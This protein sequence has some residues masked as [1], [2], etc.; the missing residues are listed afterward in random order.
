MAMK[1]RM[2]MRNFGRILCLLGLLVLGACSQEHTSAYSEQ[3][4]EDNSNTM[5]VSVSLEATVDEEQFKAISFELKNDGPALLMSEEDVNSVVVI[6]NRSKSSVYYS[7]IKWKKKTGANALSYAGTLTDL[8]T[9]RP[10]RLSSG[11]EWFMMGYLG[12]TY[13][14]ASKRVRFNPNSGGGLRALSVGEKV[15]K[16]VPIYFPWAQLNLNS[17]GDALNKSIRF[18][19]LG[20]MM[21]VE[22]KNSNTYDVRFRHLYFSSHVLSTG[23][24]YYDLSGT[25]LPNIPTNLTTAVGAS[26]PWVADATAEP[27]YP[28]L[29]NDGT[30]LDVTVKAGGTYSKYFLVWA[31]PHSSTDARTKKRTITHLLADAVRVVNGQ[32]QATPKMESVYIWGST[33]MPV[34]RKRVLLKTSLL[35]V[36]QP[37]EYF[38][39]N[40]V[41]T[42]PQ[43]S[44]P[45]ASGSTNIGTFT[46]DQMASSTFLGT[47]GTWRVP[48]LEEARG[49]FHDVGEYLRFDTQMLH[50]KTPI[51]IGPHKSPQKRVIVNNEAAD[52]ED[53]YYNGPSIYAL[54]FSGNG[55]KYYS[56]WRYT[57]PV[58]YPVKIECIYLGPHYKG[59]IDDVRQASFWDNLH[60]KDYISR[61]YNPIEIYDTSGTYRYTYPGTWVKGSISPFTR[62]T[63]AFGSP[64]DNYDAGWLMSPN[65]VIDQGQ[66]QNYARIVYWDV[67]MPVIPLEHNAGDFRQ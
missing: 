52:Y 22:L 58:K 23:S 67:K 50:T 21:R 32:E 19:P 3:A 55:Q 39:Y 13:D 31:M 44:N 17:R 35:R 20:L 34:E 37:L 51:D 18:M 43:A 45:I 29:S 36:K 60:N 48:S 1:Q 59:D 57:Y 2:L 9:G 47:S 14:K 6:S 15:D 10:L 41:S 64:K 46:Y 42:F 61:T 54:R 26:A 65:A 5:P 53:V 28:L 7:E 38:A 27:K 24:G 63:W 11:Q 8:A 33:K 56:A 25:K 16:A 12:G 30:A 49:L 40:Y 4:S 66:W 62:I